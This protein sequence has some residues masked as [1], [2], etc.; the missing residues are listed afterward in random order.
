MSHKP[1]SFHNVA[2]SFPQKICFEAFSTLIHPGDRIAIIGQNG[3]GKT[4]LLKMLQDLVEPNQGVKK[5]CDKN[6]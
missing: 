3:S 1:I 4:T 5:I 6:S 2:L